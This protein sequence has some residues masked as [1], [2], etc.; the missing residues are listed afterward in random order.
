MPLNERAGFDLL[1]DRA[2]LGD[3]GA[4]HYLAAKNTVHISSG[5]DLAAV[6]FK[7]N[8]TTPALERILGR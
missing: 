7:G 8:R 6:G 5:F 4:E 2:N 3:G 1:Y